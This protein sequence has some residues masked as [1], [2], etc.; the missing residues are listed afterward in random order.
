MTDQ[1]L[2]I[3]RLLEK[4]AEGGAGTVYRAQVTSRPESPPVALKLLDDRRLTEPQMVA[5]FRREAKILAAL[6]HRAI[7]GLLDFDEVVIGSGRDARRHLFLVLEWVEGRDLS[8]LLA[9]RGRLAVADT[10][11][12]G[13]QVADALVTAHEAGV[14]HRDLKPRTL[15]VTPRGEVRVLDFGL[16]K[17]LAESHLARQGVATFQTTA[18]AVMG[19]ARYMAPE[20][21]LGRPVDGRTDLYSLGSVLYRCL[22]GRDPFDAR[23]FLSLVRSITEE[24]PP[25]LREAR[26]EAPAPLAEL[27]HYL[28]AKE[29][30]DRPASA[31]EVRERLAGVGT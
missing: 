28:L 6:R 10:V 18:G 26:P 3:Y 16:A 12:L 2:G 14:V 29:P 1:R 20:Q 17:I 27:I 13:R 9:E 5:R 4:V 19:T 23:S 25:P 21:L 24:H 8:D 30:A 22:A 11:E 7:A 15:R 31:A